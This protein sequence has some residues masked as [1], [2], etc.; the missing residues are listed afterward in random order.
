ME[1][2]SSTKYFP[3]LVTK[4]LSKSSN[5]DNKNGFIVSRLETKSSPV[6]KFT[7]GFKGIDNSCAIWVIA[8]ALAA[9]IGSL[10]FISAS[11]LYKRVWLF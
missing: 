9:I 5:L 8:S 11:Y 4:A 6:A 1:Y 7:V 3:P 2:K 10:I